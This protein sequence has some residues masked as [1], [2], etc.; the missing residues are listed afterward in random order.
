[1][2]RILKLIVPVLLFLVTTTTSYALELV[3]NG[4]FEDY[5]I[6]GE[7]AHASNSAVPGWSNSSGRIELWNE[8][9]LISPAIGSD[10]LGTGQHHEV[11]YNNDTNITTQDS[12]IASDGFVDFS[13]DAWNRSASGIS[14]SLTGSESGLLAGGDYYFIGSEWEN[15]VHNGL[16]VVAGETL[17]LSFQSIGGGGAGAHIDQVSADYNPVPEPSTMILL[18]C[19]LVGLAGLGRKKLQK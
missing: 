1:M 13:F 19:G 10:G 2:K 5:N 17:S 15:I 7:W 9:A 3:V 12:L 8:G 4:E 11:A 16:A 18:G 14:Y 6:T